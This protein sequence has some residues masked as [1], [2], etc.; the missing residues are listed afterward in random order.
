[1]MG[2]YMCNCFYFG[3]QVEG[4][5]VWIIGSGIVGLV[6][7]FYLI[8]DGGM[9]GF[10][11]IILDVLDVIGGLLDG[12]GNFEDGYIICG[13]CEMNFNYDNLW[14]MFQDVQ[15]LELFKGYSVLDEYWLV[16]DIDLNWFKV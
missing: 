2:V 9:K 4:C 7:V 13:G 3:N 15:V 5:K 11:I 6:V 10:D 14:D 16:N 1:M 8:C 12:V